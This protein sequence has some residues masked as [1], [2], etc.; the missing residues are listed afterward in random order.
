LD[1]FTTAMAVAATASKWDIS[2]LRAARAVD[3]TSCIRRIAAKA[4]VSI[5]D[6]LVITIALYVYLFILLL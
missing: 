4:D 3:G 1:V 5:C 6:K 2:V